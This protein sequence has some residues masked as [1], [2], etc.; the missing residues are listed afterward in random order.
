MADKSFEQQVQENLAGLRMK[1]DMAVWLE[2]ERALHKERKRR[3]IIWLIL[4]AAAGGASFWGYENFSSKKSEPEIITINQITASAKSIIEEKDTASVNEKAA[5]KKEEQL[6]ANNSQVL[7]EKNKNNR[8]LPV[9]VSPKNEGSAEHPIKTQ[10]AGISTVVENKET[11]LTDQEKSSMNGSGKNSLAGAESAVAIVAPPVTTIDTAHVQEEVK[12]NEDIPS[13]KIDSVTNSQQET[14]VKINKKN[15]WLWNINV[16]AGKSGLRSGLGFGK[17]SNDN[18]TFASP[19]TGNAV[20]PAPLLTVPPTIKDAFS[21]GLQLEATKKIKKSS[22]GISAGYL[23]MQTKTGVGRKIIDSTA[24]FNSSLSQGSSRSSYYYTNTDSVD[25][26]NQYHFLQLGANYYIPFRL[27]KAVSFRWQLGMGLDFL[28]ATNG[29]HYDATNGRLFENS[30]LF[31]KTQMYMSTG[32]DLAIG[33]QPFLYIGPHWLY[34]FNSL[35][36]QGIN[37]K[38]LTRFAIQ[39]SFVLP[40]K[41]K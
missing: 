4:L 16:D 26:T 41:K 8:I 23:L 34:S 30:S 3:W 33:K 31:T 5:D 17:A 22:L 9:S 24:F 1:P 11:K 36:E 21:F 19:G 37:N 38:Y 32:L 35:S 29:L 14:T 28:I 27:F 6:F 25:Y 20:P 7:T 13:A 40:K 2:V 12:I 15:P 10:P 18:L 39:A